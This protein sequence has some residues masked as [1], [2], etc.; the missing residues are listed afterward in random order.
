[1]QCSAHSMHAV[2]CHNSVCRLLIRCFTRAWV[3]A[4]G[5]CLCR[6]DG[7]MHASGVR[8]TPSEELWLFY[9]L[10]LSFLQVAAQPE[11]RQEH[12]L[13]AQ[14][15][16]EELLTSSLLTAGAQLPPE[17]TP[18]ELTDVSISRL[19]S[20]SGGSS[21][22]GL[23]AGAA[24]DSQDPA[25][26]SLTSD[27]SGGPNSQPGA[28][29]ATAE[30]Q[31]QQAAAPARVPALNLPG[32]SRPGT[33]A[34]TGTSRSAA[35]SSALLTTRGVIRDRQL[36]GS[37]LEWAVWQPDSELLQKLREAAAAAD[38]STHS[39]RRSSS[40]A[41]SRPNSVAAGGASSKGVS[42][43][44][45]S[46]GVTATAP[47]AA[48]AG[49]VTEAETSCGSPGGVAL[50]RSTMQAPEL[51]MA[52]LQVLSELLQ[53]AGHHVAALPVL[54]LA[55]LVALVPLNS[56]V[57]VLHRSCCRS[58]YTLAADWCQQ[59]RSTC[60]RVLA[61]PAEVTTVCTWP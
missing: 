41:N 40:S 51:L 31:Q 17:A 10:L 35:L 16:A 4:S 42:T 43:A 6:L 36:P 30:Q 39:A 26:G 50:S 21:G 52:H 13:A 60:L 49:G 2:F 44:A 5:A 15:C 53:A 46:P 28:A 14:A 59:S 55:R 45:G 25:T 37:V 61:A 29:H 47:A 54:H 48:A 58:K 34:A 19:C 3:L 32:G 27:S 9:L 57:R 20:S 38:A 11:V 8:S 18:P 22:L 56:Q 33:A 12:L 7:C 1:V 24:P 23:V